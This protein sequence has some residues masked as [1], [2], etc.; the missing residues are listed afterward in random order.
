M[1]IHYVSEGGILIAISEL[2]IKNNIGVYLT[3]LLEH[4]LDN[5]INFLFGE[6]QSRYLVAINESKINNVNNLLNKTELSRFE[7]SNLLDSD[8]FLKQEDR[9]IDNSEIIKSDFYLE[10]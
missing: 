6:D 4:T 10:S 7:I 8:N 1:G 5:I 2:I 9:H 3:N